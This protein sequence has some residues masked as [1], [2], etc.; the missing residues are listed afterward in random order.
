M[1]SHLTIKDLA[2]M[3]SASITFSPHM[4]VITGETGSGKSIIIKALGLLFGDKSD[5]DLVHS[6]ASQ[7]MV[8]GGFRVTSYSHRIF[9]VL[10]DHGLIDE[11][12]KKSIMIRRVLHRKGRS[13]C[14]INDVPVTIKT[15]KKVSSYLMDVFSQNEQ[16]K[17]MNPAEQIAYLDQFLTTDEILEE[18]R[19]QYD[20]CQKQ[21]AALKTLLG[22]HEDKKH[23]LDYLEFRLSELTGLDPSPDDYAM[24]LEYCQKA[25]FALKNQ[26]NLTEINDIIDHGYNGASLAKAL[27]QVKDRL[28]TIESVEMQKIA[29][30]CETAAN[31]IDEVSF[32]MERALQDCQVDHAQLEDNQGR[33]ASYQHF[34]RKFSVSSAEELVQKREELEQQIDN[35]TQIHKH[36]EDMLVTLDKD[37][38]ALDKLAATLTDQRN[39]AKAKMI[40][41]INTELEELNMKG[42]KIDVAFHDTSTLLPI[43]DLNEFDSK[44]QELWANICENLVSITKTGKERIEIYLS[45]NPGEPPKP[46]NKVASGGEMSRIMLAFKNI[47]SH[48]NVDYFL[49]FDEVDTGISGVTA[50]IIGRKLKSLAENCQMLCISHLPQVASYGDHHLLVEKSTRAGKTTSKVTILDDK[51]RTTEIARLLSGSEI[52]VEGIENAMKLLQRAA[53]PT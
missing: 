29:S 4:N 2:I 34:M 44:I 51:D 8:A 16:L 42:S 26:Q 28:A 49:V 14:W 33:L 20:H 30:E 27:W 21:L 46:L 53:T 3:E 48:H 1:L 10:R 41:Q 36:L 43:L 9:D 23:N 25:S 40:S 37:A 32:Q 18:F 17:L 31:T 7:A 47:V 39:H 11:E 35:V 13:Q 12:D 45:A 15:L 22:D 19:K 6:K 5:Y 38:A 52:T 50:D 24:L